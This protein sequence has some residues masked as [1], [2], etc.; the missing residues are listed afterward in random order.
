MYID[1]NAPNFIK[2]IDVIDFLGT[3]EV[4]LIEPKHVHY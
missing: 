1:L 4:Y 3:K 2:C